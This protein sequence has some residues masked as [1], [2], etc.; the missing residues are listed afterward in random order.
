MSGVRLPHNLRFQGGA[1]KNSETTASIAD[2]SRTEKSVD[3]KLTNRAAGVGDLR[4][5]SEV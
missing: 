1:K 3:F 4:D 2:K 5:F